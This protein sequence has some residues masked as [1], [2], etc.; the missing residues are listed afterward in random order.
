M[1]F[2]N[3]QM[4]NHNRCQ[5][6]LIYRGTLILFEMSVKSKIMNV[7]TAH[8]KLVTFAIG[9]GITMAIGTAIGMVGINQALAINPGGAGS[10][11]GGA[12]GA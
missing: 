6:S 11:T 1:V 10:T 9:L 3:Y 2:A 8:P 12:G 7:M 4:K 5:H